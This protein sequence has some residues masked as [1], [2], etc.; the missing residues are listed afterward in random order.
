VSPSKEHDYLQ[1]IALLK[2]R[3]M[4]YPVVY[5]EVYTGYIN[6]ILDAVGIVHGGMFYRPGGSPYQ[7]AGI[8]VK[9]SRADYYSEK[10]RAVAHKSAGIHSKSQFGINYRYFL[11]PKGLIK[12]D[13]L[14][15]GW[16]LMEF[17]GKQ[18]RMIVD[19]PRYEVDDRICFE[20]ARRP[21][22]VFHQKETYLLDGYDWVTYGIVER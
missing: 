6:G 19:S 2:L 4:G 18:V 1:K 9:I 3:Y 17:D 11:V 7:S 16:G 10:Q 8:E 12:L 20:M 13:E 22:V 15:E 21:H 14:Y 5:P